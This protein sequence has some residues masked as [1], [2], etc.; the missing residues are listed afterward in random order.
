VQTHTQTNRCGK[1]KEG[2]KLK[3]FYNIG[4]QKET[5]VFFNV[6]RYAG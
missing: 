6:E 5:V 4:D 3:L 1:Y 2:T